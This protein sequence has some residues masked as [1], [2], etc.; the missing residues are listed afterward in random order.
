MEEQGETKELAPLGFMSAESIWRLSHGGNCKGAVPVHMNESPVSKHAV[1]LLR[2]AMAA[3][4]HEKRRAALTFYQRFAI[5]WAHQVEEGDREKIRQF[6]EGW[7][8][9]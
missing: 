5:E 7:Y 3:I 6:I 2:D 9:K 4:E 1:V 8:G